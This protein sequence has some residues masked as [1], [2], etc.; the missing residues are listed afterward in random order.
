[1]HPPC[2]PVP[3][4]HLPTLLRP[5]RAHQAPMHPLYHAHSLL[6]APHSQ[7]RRRH[8]CPVLLRPRSPLPLAF[9]K[10]LVTYHPV[11]RLLSP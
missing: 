7:V 5:P 6:L 1:M 9:P 3:L 8:H 11:R 2:H 4:R 10:I